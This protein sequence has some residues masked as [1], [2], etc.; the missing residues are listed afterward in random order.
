[1]RIP[2][3]DS[4]VGGE[5]RVRGYSLFTGEGSES[6][7]ASSHA[8][9]SINQEMRLTHFKPRAVAIAQ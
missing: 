2:G 3:V 7:N 6:V 9:H 1:M 8:Q 5:A 4:D